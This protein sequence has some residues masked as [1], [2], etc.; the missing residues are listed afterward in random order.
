MHLP[1]RR[2]ATATV[3]TLIITVMLSAP[4]TPARAATTRG[5]IGAGLRGPAG[6]SATV[7][8]KGLEHASALAIDGQGRVW[9]ATAAADDEADDRIAL[10]ATAGAAPQT[11]VTD[12]DTPLGLV[13]VGETL[14]V[15]LHGGVLA[16][17]GFD[18]TA[19]ASRATV[20]SFPDGTGEVNGIALGNDGRLYVGISA[21]CDACKPADAVSASVVS[22]RPDGTDLQV[23]ANHIRAPIGLAFFPGTDDLFVT[24][25]QRDDLGDETPGDWLALVEAG[26][27]W[28]FPRCYG[29]SSTRC[30]A[31]P[32]PVAELHD[33]AA[34]SG[35]AIVTGEL[36][37]RVGTGAVVAEWMTGAVRL[38]RLTTSDAGYTGTTTAFLAGFRN[39]VPV[40]LAPDGALFVGDWTSGK[41][42]RITA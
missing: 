12:L 13:W 11:V 36:G 21:P 20:A 33:H 4:V 27:S 38:V 42:Y 34:V 32:E 6:L 1:L 15:S 18:G 37:A 7:Y 16:F 9:I 14:Y 10:V 3:V 22:F 8:A 35:V 19:F 2:V 24:M 39:P 17:S 30:A 40:A 31:Q 23:F 41:L 29:Q 26:Q 25:N 5:P 28:Q